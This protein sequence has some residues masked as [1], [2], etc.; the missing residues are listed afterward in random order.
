MRNPPGLRLILARTGL[1]GYGPLDSS[2]FIEGGELALFQSGVSWRKTKK[3]GEVFVWK[4]LRTCCG[5]SGRVTRWV[6]GVCLT[7]YIYIYI[8]YIKKVYYSELATNIYFLFFLT[9]EIRDGDVIRTTGL[10]SG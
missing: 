9:S 7:V 2:R 3:C 6:E 5:T 8:A 1:N 4:H 10:I